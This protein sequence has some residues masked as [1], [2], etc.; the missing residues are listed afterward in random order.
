MRWASLW[1]KECPRMVLSSASD[2]HGAVCASWETAASRISGYW[3]RAR[4]AAPVTLVTSG[5]LAPSP[6]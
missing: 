5:G 6:N 3:G 4:S 2:V 1:P